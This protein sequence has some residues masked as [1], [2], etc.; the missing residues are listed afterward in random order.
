MGQTLKH[1]RSSALTN[2]QPKL[3]T[4]SQIGYGE[5]AINFAEGHE[6]L[7][8]RNSNDGI[9]TFSSD[10][11]LAGKYIESGAVVNAISAVTVSMEDNEYV[12]AQALNDQD[13]RIEALENGGF[14]TG[15]TETDPT[16]PAWAKA[17]NK[18]SYTANEV[19]ALP[20]TT[21]V[22]TEASIANSGF[23]KNALTAYTETDPTVPAWA[24]A[25]NKPTYTAS[26]VGALA[27][28]TTLDGIADGSTRKLS[29]FFD[30]AE[31]DSNTK[32]IN[33]KNGGTVKDYIDATAFIKDGMV[34]SVTVDNGNLVMSFN[35]DAGREDITLALTQIF[36]PSNYYDKTAADAKFLSAYTETDPT[37]P[38]WAKEANKP[39]Y[40]ASEVGALPSTT[41]VPTEASITNSGF[42]KNALTAYTETDPI[43]TGS[44][45]YGITSQNITDWGNKQ[46][47]ISDLEQIRRSAA[48]GLSAY[49]T[50]TAHTA[51]T[52][53]HVTSSDKTTWNG[54][55]D[56]ISDLATIRYNAASGMSAY[57]TATAHTADTTIHVTSSD[58]TTWNG[59]QDSI[60]DLAAIRYNAASGMS[61]YNTVTAHTAST[62]A[63]LPSVSASDNGK[64]L[65]VVNGVWTLVTPTT[66]YTGTGTPD[67]LLGN[68]GD[69]YLQTS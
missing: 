23:T 43:F 44:P 10:A 64:I 7:S 50:V 62:T 20:N 1:K 49:G 4:T 5:I 29:V 52:T 25:D 28:G 26:E 15:F 60:S 34:S 16:V 6:T 39:S 68:N 14:L 24:K 9:A 36:N 35:T 59:K 21:H 19:G 55:Q 2:G 54:K 53:I 66:V 57:N 30:D 22:P 12:I 67:N 51:D 45:A 56:S 17:E 18:P 27:T 65:Q 33:F 8:I 61:A 63:H 13:D 48:S 46:N 47:A 58:K 37:V 69:I 3:P 38:A 42:T 31:Y 32:R 41:H 40:T 11:V